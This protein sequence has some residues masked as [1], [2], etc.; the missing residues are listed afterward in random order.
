[1][2]AADATDT[3]PA[4]EEFR[5]T[6]RRS[7]F[8]ARLPRHLTSAALAVLVCVGLRSLLFAPAPTPAPAHPAGS[9][10]VPSED[11]ALRFARAYL[12]YDAADPAARTDALAPY[13][14]TADSS[15]GGFTAAHGS[16]HVLWEDVAS[17]QPAL[18][19]GRVVTV[20]A[21]TSGSSVP[22]FLAVTV[23]RDPGRPLSIVS[24]PA[25]VGAPAL[26]TH[27]PEAARTAVEDP[28]VTQVVERVLRNYL[29]GS[30]P[31]LRA[32]LTADAQVTLP[33]AALRVT[34]VGPVDW[35]SGPGSGAVLA[36]A[37]AEDDEG[38][39]WTLTYELGIAWHERPYVDFVEVVP[40][41]S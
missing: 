38:D 16:R 27:P 5:R 37:V 14:P 20:A 29:A 22:I 33:T 23:R 10:D 24:Y 32:D 34:R 13:L 4:V 2:S 15:E 21:Q 18:Q 17:D 25:I 40:T 11:L 12:T 35:V 1:M 7:R 6:V 8:L 36:T 3:R 9:L 19:G 26:D 30:A 28:A 39:T 41:R 31:N